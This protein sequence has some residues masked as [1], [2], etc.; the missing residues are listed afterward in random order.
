[1][2][3]KG[4]AEKQ[5]TELSSGSTRGFPPPAFA[6]ASP[7][8]GEGEAMAKAGGDMRKDVYVIGKRNM[9]TRFSHIGSSIY[10]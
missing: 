3:G 1:M 4:P 2:A 8:S 6:I 10:E 5:G 7:G 9:A